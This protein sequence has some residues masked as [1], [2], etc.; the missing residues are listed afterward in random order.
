MENLVRVDIP[1]E[2]KPQEAP[3]NQAKK[4][5]IAE[6][7]ENLTDLVNE[8]AYGGQR[9]VVM[10]RGKELAALVPMEDLHALRLIAVQQMSVTQDARSFSVTLPYGTATTQRVDDGAGTPNEKL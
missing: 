7:R 3:G 10:R 5:N 1:A 8:V 4:L 9:L 2:I 6:A